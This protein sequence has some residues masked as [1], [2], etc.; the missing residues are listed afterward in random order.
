MHFPKQINF[1]EQKIIDSYLLDDDSYDKILD[2]T[3]SSSK[4]EIAKARMIEMIQ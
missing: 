1:K 2:Y 4:N 3:F